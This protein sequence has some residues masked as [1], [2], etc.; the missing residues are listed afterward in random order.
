MA[1][2]AVIR[3]AIHHDLNGLLALYR[4]LNPKDPIPDETKLRD[5]WRDLLDLRAQPSSLPSVKTHWSQH[6]R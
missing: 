2:H 3:A 5:A 1:S 6:A 4:F